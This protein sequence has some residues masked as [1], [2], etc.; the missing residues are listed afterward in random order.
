MNPS[1]IVLVF[2]TIALHSFILSPAN[3]Q[4]RRGKLAKL[5]AAAP[6][7]PYET[8]NN[9]CLYRRLDV[10]R[11][12]CLSVLKKGH[13]AYA[14]RNDLVPLLEV[15]INATS[16]YTCK[17]ISF[18]QN[19]YDKKQTKAVGECLSAYEEIAGYMT[20][21]IT[22]ISQEPVVAGSDGEVINNYVNRCVKAASKLKSTEIS[23]KNQEATKYARLMI[24]IADG[25]SNGTPL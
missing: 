5:A 15:A 21:V 23:D 25:L 20:K 22:D 9:F 13:A 6:P 24:D 10:E 16:I 2:F 1:K 12:F 14:K 19:I 8:V 7:V 4:N 18:L 17:T 11:S 3:A